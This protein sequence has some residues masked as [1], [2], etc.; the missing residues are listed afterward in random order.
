MATKLHS[1]AKKMTCTT[2]TVPTTQGK[3]ALMRSQCKSH[4]MMFVHN[5]A[6]FASLAAKKTRNSFKN[7]ARALP[8]P[9]FQILHNSIVDYL[10][11]EGTIKVC[12]VRAT[13]HRLK[14]EIV[15]GDGLKL[16]V[17]GIPDLFEKGNSVAVGPLID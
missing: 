13:L 1:E 2:N 17:P 4:I 11:V 12:R 10:E 8:S 5:F 3:S 9:E 16:I 15:R 7:S 6:Y 14:S